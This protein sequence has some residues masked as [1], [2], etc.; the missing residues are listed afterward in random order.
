MHVVP[1][2][3]AECLIL[4]ASSVFV[5][6]GGVEEP[7]RV[8]LGSVDPIFQDGLRAVASERG[9]PFVIQFEHPL[10]AVQRARMKNGGVD[11]LGRSARLISPS[12][13]LT[14]SSLERWLS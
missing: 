10:S 5:L 9:E 13:E 14:D 2:F 8:R 12:P 11:L 7:Y 3:I 6:A 4:G 1:L